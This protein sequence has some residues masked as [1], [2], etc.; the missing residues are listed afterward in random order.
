MAVG[1]RNARKGAVGRADLVRLLTLF[2]NHPPEQ[3]ASFLGYDYTPTE[4]IVEEPPRLPDTPEEQETAE[5]QT[6]ELQSPWF[7]HIVKRERFSSDKPGDIPPEEMPPAVPTHLPDMKGP[8]PEFSPLVPWVRLWPLLRDIVA[9]HLYSRQPDE[10]EA[11]RLLSRGEHLVDIPRKKR[12]AWSARL[13]ILVDCSDPLIPFWDDFY[14]I[15][16]GI[17]RHVGKNSLT[18]S[19]AEFGPLN[20][21]FDLRTGEYVPFSSFPVELPCLIFSDCGVYSTREMRE[22]WEEFGRLFSRR[23]C[24]PAIISPVP[25]RLVQKNIANLFRVVCLDDHAPVRFTSSGANPSMV[26]ADAGDSTPSESLLALCS[27]AVRVEPQLLRAVRRL[28]PEAD[29]GTEGMAW[30][31]V[32]VEPNPL[33]FS[34]KTSGENSHETLRKK[35]ATLPKCLRKAADKLINLYHSGLPAEVQLEERLTQYTLRLSDNPNLPVPQDVLQYLQWLGERSEEVVEPGMLKAWVRRMG[36]RQLSELKR[37]TPWAKPLKKVVAAAFAEELRSAQSHK[38]PPLVSDDDIEALE[39]SAP[40]Q[41]K[42]W[43][44]VQEGEKLLFKELGNFDRGCPFGVLPAKRIVEVVLPKQHASYTLSN[45][46]SISLPRQ[47]T[48]SIV[49]SEESLTLGSMQKPKWADSIVQNAKGLYATLPLNDSKIK[50]VLP[51]D[52]KRIYLEQTGEVPEA[53]G[54]L[55]WGL[56]PSYD[57]VRP[58]GDYDEYFGLVSSQEH[59]RWVNISQLEKFSG[60]K[61]PDVSWAVAEGIDQYGLYADLRIKGIIQRMRWIHPGTFLMGSPESEPE[62]DDDETQHGVTLTR[63]FWLADATCTQE[64]WEA[65]M[66]NNPSKFSGEPELP[67]EKVSWKDCQD[68]CQKV[69]ALLPNIRLT[70]PTEAQ[71]E[72]ACRA[73]TETPFS[74][75]ENITPEQVNYAGTSPYAGG[76]KGLYRGN[77]VP[78]KALECNQWGLYQMHGNVWEWCQDWYGEYPTSSVVDPSGA[79]SGGDRVLRGGS[80][81]LNGR[82]VRSACRLRVVPGYRDHNTGFRFSLGR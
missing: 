79:D 48:I 67:V 29:V 60:K 39:E 56:S 63:G 77:T 76:Q 3:I 59:A 22:Q 5:K 10:A 23:G 32:D 42:D 80:W 16:Q 72:Y 24:K 54:L 44:L 25:Q 74:F 49:S 41:A 28:L 82:H 15:I 31:H 21:T 46:F 53:L 52:L 13:H 62:R 65:V 19:C 30:N 12:K 43:I 69:N 6:P 81:I 1:K 36:H 37:E 55:R 26:P 61:L 20:G 40:S 17:M 27:P 68:F 51:S 8:V 18:V 34:F 38:I 45:G 58:V 57:E 11:V 73:G 9:G 35:F 47:E 66:E 2:P 71:W 4:A 33:A 75:G 64:L 50:W 7:W 14:M 70:L 78:V